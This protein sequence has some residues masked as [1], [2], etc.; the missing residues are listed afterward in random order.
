M[1]IWNA[2]SRANGVVTPRA[3]DFVWRRKPSDS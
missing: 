1:P 3:V 2:E